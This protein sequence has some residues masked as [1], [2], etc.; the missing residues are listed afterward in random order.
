MQQLIHALRAVLV[1]PVLGI[2]AVLWAP[3]TIVEAQTFV[4]TASAQGVDILVNSDFFG[5]GVSSYDI[6]ED[7]WDDLSFA[8]THDSLFFYRNNMGQLERLPSF[9]DAS[10]ETKHVLW[11]DY[12]NDGDL[13][14]TVST[15]TGT[16]RLYANDGAF[17]FT[18]VSEEVGFP[19]VVAENYGAAWADYDRDGD[20]DLY[21]GNGV[22]FGDVN[23]YS[24]LNH[25]YQNTGN[26]TFTDVTLAAGVADSIRFTLQPVWLDYDSDGWP[27]LYVANDKAFRSSMYH[28]NGDGTF[29]D[30]TEQTGTGFADDEPMTT[31]VADF[32]NDGDL[33]I[34]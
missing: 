26:G 8:T 14:I 33:D 3:C 28:N 5:S 22:A 12:D 15:F 25:L 29:S 24:L 13:D 30:V 16:L 9:A 7:G 31:S 19:Q 4:N 2:A 34:Y 27:D 21:M 23:N 11:V 32:D 20:L 6:D 18:D 10:G 17:H 1:R